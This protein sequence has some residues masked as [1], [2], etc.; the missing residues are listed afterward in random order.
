MASILATDVPEKFW[1]KWR[2]SLHGKEHTPQSPVMPRL[3]DQEDVV[4]EIAPGNGKGG[5]LKENG[6]REEKGS[7][8]KEILWR[9]L[10][11]V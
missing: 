1:R 9:V 6:T 3:R 11:C 7:I 4:A 10:G 2:G 8:R 5:P